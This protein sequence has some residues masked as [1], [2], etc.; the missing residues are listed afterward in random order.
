MSRC[1]NHDV[2]VS[3]EGRLTK[4]EIAVIE[5][6]GL[7]EKLANR[8]IFIVAANC[9]STKGLPNMIESQQEAIRL[10]LEFLGRKH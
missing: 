6:Q 3:V 8:I 9:S 2:L 7:V 10:A 1:P 4:A 5:L